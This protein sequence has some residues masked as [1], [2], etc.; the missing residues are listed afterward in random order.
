MA[1]EAADEESATYDAYSDEDGAA[2][3]EE[4]EARY[5]KSQWSKLLIHANFDGT[6]YEIG[7]W[8]TFEPLI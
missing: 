5:G 6:K 3:E 1:E 2:E 4:D 7:D 8:D